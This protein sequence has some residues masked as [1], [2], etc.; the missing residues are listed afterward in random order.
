MKRF[1]CRHVHL[2]GTLEKYTIVQNAAN[3]LQLSG[4]FQLLK[5]KAIEIIFKKNSPQSK[6]LFTQKMLVLIVE[7]FVEYFIKLTVPDDIA[8]EL[9]Q[10]RQGK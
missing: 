2:A 10:Q 6:L 3:K 8:I 9:Y 7:P 5:T 1:D 4:I